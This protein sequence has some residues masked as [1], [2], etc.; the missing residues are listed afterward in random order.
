MLRS[1]YLNRKRIPSFKLAF[2]LLLVDIRDMNPQ[3]GK[4]EKKPKKVGETTF[5][6]SLSINETAE[7]ESDS[8]FLVHSIIM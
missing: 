7:D 4:L 1:S 8:I 3:F 6:P 2:S 5:I